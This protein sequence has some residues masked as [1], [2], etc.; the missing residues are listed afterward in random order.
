[1]V[2]GW[3]RKSVRHDIDHR[4]LPRFGYARDQ[5]NREAKAVTAGFF[6]RRAVLAATVECSFLFALGA[7]APAAH[8]AE[9]KVISTVAL[10]PTL[11]ELT[12]KYESGSGNKLMI[13]QHDRGSEEADRGG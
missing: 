3:L 11:G 2:K 12:P 7:A 4:S 5:A 8:A 6:S 13:V 1:M 10:T 9:V